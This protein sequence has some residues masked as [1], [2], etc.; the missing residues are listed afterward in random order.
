MPSLSSRPL[1]ICASMYLAVRTVT[2]D[3]LADIG[4][5]FVHFNRNS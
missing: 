2:N 4:I 1:I 3:S 5:A